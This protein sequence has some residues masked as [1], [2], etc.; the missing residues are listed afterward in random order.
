MSSRELQTTVRVTEALRG[1]PVHSLKNDI[2]PAVCV[3]GDFDARV[4][5]LRRPERG[6]KSFV[7]LT[8][9]RSGSYLL[10][11]L[12]TRLGLG[13]PEEHLKDPI[14]D[15]IRDRDR[16]D[17][18]I[19]AWLKSLEVSQQVGGSEPW[20]GTKLI[21]HYVRRLRDVLL[22]SEREWLDGW[23][24]SSRLLTL[25]RKDRVKQ[26]VSA[27]RAQKTGVY[28]ARSVIDQERA[29]TQE[30]PYDFDRLLEVFEFLRSE[31]AFIDDYAEHVTP[32]AQRIDLA[33]EDFSI[34]IPGTIETLARFAGVPSVSPPNRTE[35]RAV[36]SDSSRQMVDRFRSDLAAR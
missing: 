22:E 14:I 13:Q 15:A 26:A 9:M 7:I 31:D 6:C 29:H 10:A 5:L 11:E 30:V 3:G 16:R 8:V 34:D 33:Y 18:S 32:A 24:S 27:Y 1:I 4:G 12:A 17:L 36:S 23:L 2:H 21:S 28:R 35:N 20:F 19:R 25:K